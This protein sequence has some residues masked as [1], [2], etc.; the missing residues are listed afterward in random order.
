MEFLM[1]NQKSSFKTS[2]KIQEYIK[3][4]SSDINKAITAVY[5][6]RNHLIRE[7]KETNNLLI[8]LTSQLDID[9]K[10]KKLNRF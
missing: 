7:L 8:Q 3:T 2:P 1:L 6:K 5:T 9:E 10:Y 4:C